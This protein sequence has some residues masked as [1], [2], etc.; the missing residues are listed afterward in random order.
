MLLTILVIS[1]I[2]SCSAQRH[3]SDGD[4]AKGFVA[5]SDVNPSGES[6]Y[7]VLFIRDAAGRTVVEGE[8]GFSE[9]GYL[10]L[11]DGPTQPL[12]FS[13]DVPPSMLRP[14]TL[15]HVS[16]EYVSASGER[17]SLGTATIECAGYPSTHG[18]QYLLFIRRNMPHAKS[19]SPVLY[20]TWNGV[21]EYDAARHYGLY[22]NLNG[23]TSDGERLTV[24]PDGRPVRIPFG[25]VLSGDDRLSGSG[26]IVPVA[27][28]WVGDRCTDI[29]R[30]EGLPVRVDGLSSLAAERSVMKDIVVKKNVVEAESFSIFFRTGRSD[31]DLSVADNAAEV[32]R[33]KEVVSSKMSREGFVLDSV[34][35]SAWASPE[36]TEKYNASLSSDRASSAASLF[37]DCIVSEGGA[38]KGNSSRRHSPFIP[39]YPEGKGEDWE[40]LDELIAASPSLTRADRESYSS[41][42]RIASLDEREAKMKERPWYSYVKDEL[43]PL[44]RVVE[45]GF[46]CHRP[47]M[48]VDS[49]VTRGVDTAYAEGLSA[50]RNGEER[51]ARILLEGYGD[52]NSALACLMDGDAPG[53]LR[54][55]SSLEECPAVDY[56]NALA[57]ASMGEKG[58]ALTSLRR[59]VSGSAAFRSLA[60][61]EPLFNG[62]DI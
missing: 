5:L 54:I 15:L 50:L 52:Y 41:I 43:Y 19:S 49:L 55:L 10:F 23:E 31:I 40:T 13:V 30:G 36:G 24:V 7:P 32:A 60:L 27:D 6:L 38:V 2:L 58:K 44:L 62:Y 16:P 3:A 42:R 48:E 26:T 34:I 29:V 28:V 46:H 51:K 37:R 21:T 1:G 35:V 4:S 11:S 53:C 39:V 33:F 14:G 61:R 18:R 22:H 20:A 17:R 56:L 8:G 9:G 45:A 59:S 57:Y 12:S 25:S 47:G